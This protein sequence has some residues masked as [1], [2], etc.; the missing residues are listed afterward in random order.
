MDQATLDV[1]LGISGSFE[2]NAPNY[3]ALTG[4]FDG[5]GLSVGVLQWCA[6]QGSLGHLLTRIAQLG[7]DLDSLGVAQI[8]QMHN[9]QAVQFCVQNFL[10]GAGNPT[11]EAHQQ[12]GALL[13]SEAGIQA[14]VQLASEGPLGKAMALAAAYCPEAPEHLR[15]LAFFFDIVV[16]SG[17]M[18]NSRGHVDPIGP[19]GQ[20]PE[21]MA[22]IQSK[23]K[24]YAQARQG[25]DDLAQHLLYYAYHRAQLSKPEYMWDAFSR[26]ATVACR[27]GIVHGLAFDLT[28]RLP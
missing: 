16:Q 15:V 13:G 28:D 18:G 21:I 2:N 5:Q 1:C 12:W 3:Q 6:G 20:D 22:Y 26:R 24:F 23:P 14:Q 25:F 17:S 7:G 9:A 10:D 11:P 8:P 27:H 4:N 19:C